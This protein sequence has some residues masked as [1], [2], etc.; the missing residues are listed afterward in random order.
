M[1]LKIFLDTAIVSKTGLHDPCIYY[2]IHILC[3]IYT[4]KWCSILY[5]SRDYSLSTALVVRVSSPV[6]YV[7]MS[8]DLYTH[9]YCDTH[10]ESLI[11]ISSDFHHLQ[12][13]KYRYILVNHSG[14]TLSN[15]SMKVILWS[16][17]LFSFFSLYLNAPLLHS[18]KLDYVRLSCLSC[19]RVFQKCYSNMVLSFQKES[20]FY[21]YSQRVQGIQQKSN[22]QDLKVL[23]VLGPDTFCLDH[24]FFW[25][26]KNWGVQRDSA[27]E[28]LHHNQEVNSASQL[29]KWTAC[30]FSVH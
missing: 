24:T 3:K 14:H 28:T 5:R 22:P 8:C 17:I 16:P 25:N 30:F 7:K 27:I 12:Q 23:P 2:M 6:W 20:W 15:S 21:E 9:L 13:N 10:L 11:F 1:S 19:Q 18:M 29:I 26:N 4:V